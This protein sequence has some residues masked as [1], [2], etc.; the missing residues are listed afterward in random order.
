MDNTSNIRPNFYPLIG[1]VIGIFFAYA[2]EVGLFETWHSLGRPPEPISRI[3]GANE[4]TV[5]VLTDT[6]KTFSFTY[7]QPGGALS[8]TWEEVNDNNYKIISNYHAGYFISLPP[9]FKTTQAYELN[10]HPLMEAGGQV[11]LALANDKTVWMWKHSSAGMAVYCLSIFPGIGLGIGL[12][13]SKIRARDNKQ[14]QL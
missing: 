9:L 13:L 3:I 14:L 6:G 7:F 8:N 12:L 5:Y 1:L 4:N 11:K 10:V 2:L